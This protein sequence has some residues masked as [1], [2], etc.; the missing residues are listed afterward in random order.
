MPQYTVT[1]IDLVIFFGYLFGTRIIFGWYAARK[2]QKEK[3][4]ESYFLGGRNLRWPLIGLSFYVANMSGGSFVALPGSGYHNGIAVYNYEWMPAI[5]LIFFV[6]FFLPAFLKAKIFTSPEF[7]EK[8]YNA[9]SRLILSGFFILTSL[10]IDAAA[11]LYAG[12]TIVKAL[13]P[14]FP[15]WMTIAI[16]ALIAGVYIA[17]GG[18]RAVVLND[19]V[20]AIL[21][22]TGGTILTILTFQEIES[23]EASKPLRRTAHC[24]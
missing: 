12:G 22:V 14:S 3:G 7:L 1:A 15:F 23:W 9:T 4:A 13:Y 17:F 6:L 5:I 24:N 18:L 8:R 10:L 20:Q 2:V 21:I 19:V 16:G 11:S